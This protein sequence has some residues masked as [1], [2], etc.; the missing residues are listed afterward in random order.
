MRRRTFLRLMVLG[1]SALGS[2]RTLRAAGRGSMRPDA[3]ASPY[4]RWVRRAGLPAFVYEADQD[5]F[6]GAEWDPIL[7]PRTRRHW[8]MVGNRAIRLQAANDGTLGLLDER[9]GLRW[10]VAPDPTGTGVSIVDEGA[11]GVRRQ[12]ELHIGLAKAL[13]E[14]DRARACFHRLADAIVHAGDHLLDERRAL[15]AGAT[16]AIGEVVRGEV[17]ARADDGHLVVPREL[18]AVV[19]KEVDLGGVP[20]RLGVEQQAVHVEDDGPIPTV[21]R[22]AQE[23][24]SKNDPPD[25]ASD[26]RSG[27][28]R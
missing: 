22:H 8:I 14:L 19:A 6:P 16:Q 9:D 1:G 10:L 20:Q 13:D 26:R 23:R 12:P 27:T 3:G 11:R 15:G 18:A 7:A 25:S 28:V 4:G 5:A 24:D 17:V 21:Q 2:P